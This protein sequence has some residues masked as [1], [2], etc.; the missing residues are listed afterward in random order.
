MKY[1]WKE[2]RQKFSDVGCMHGCVLSWAGRQAFGPSVEHM[3][4]LVGEHQDEGVL[5]VCMSVIMSVLGML[6]SDT[7]Q[8]KYLS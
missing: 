4:H 7:H 8:D 2:V 5:S 6:Q 3:V 1:A